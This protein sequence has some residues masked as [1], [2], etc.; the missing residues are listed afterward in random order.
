[1]QS[2]LTMSFRLSAMG[3]PA[4]VYMM[5]SGG[6][7]LLSFVFF[8]L[9][10]RVHK[11][12]RIKSTPMSKIKDA[13]PGWVALSGVGRARHLTRDPV[14][15]R[16]CYW[17]RCVVQDYDADTT[18]QWYDMRDIATTELFYLDDDTGSIVVDPQHAE[19]RV[20]DVAEEVVRLSPEN[21]DWLAPILAGWGFKL[22]GS[23]IDLLLN[24]LGRRFGLG[25][26][27]L[28]HIR[29]KVQTLQYS[30]PMLVLGHLSRGTLKPQ[31]IFIA[32][33][34]Q[35]ELFRRTAND[36]RAGFL[37][38]SVLG[39]GLTLFG[40]ANARW[41]L[42]AP[43]APALIDAGAITGLVIGWTAAKK[44]G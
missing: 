36:E 41:F 12:R 13:K 14:L 8:T 43:L 28:M 35:F 29:V 30:V 7:M 25:L 9:F 27:A 26:I 32:T 16:P 18:D 21:Y 40:V 2:R 17:W 5:M 10:F 1:V 3:W 38:A 22:L 11:Y 42:H 44:R 19:Y 23:K 6:V 33:T 24:R 31:H 34:P 39:T 4:S 20:E 15:D 37:F